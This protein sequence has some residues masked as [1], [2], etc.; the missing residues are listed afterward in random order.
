MQTIIAV[1]TDWSLDGKIADIVRD[2]RGKFID[3]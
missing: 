2:S 1:F 3:W